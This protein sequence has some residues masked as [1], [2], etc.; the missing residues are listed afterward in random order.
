MGRDE[1]ELHD[2]LGRNP[3]T[4]PLLNA[5]YQATVEIEEGPSRLI[6]STLGESWI[7]GSSTNGIFGANTSTVSGSQQVVGSSGRVDTLRS[8][9][10]PFNRFTEHFRDEEYVDS[11]NTTASVDTSTNYRVDF[12]SGEV[13]TSSTIFK[14]SQ[15]VTSVTA[16]WTQTGSVDFEISADGGS[17]WT[18]VSNGEETVLDSAKIGQDLRYRV[19][20]T[21][22]ST[23]TISEIKII[24]EA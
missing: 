16:F 1:A 17:S 12:T 9:V 18:T 15:D 22:A 5:N 23:A 13:F 8:V 2:Q 3:D 4:F 21:G 11:G 20:E 14:D 7:V 10:N 19:T 6:T 24:Y